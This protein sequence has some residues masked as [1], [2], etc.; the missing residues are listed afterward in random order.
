MGNEERKYVYG[1]KVEE[2][3]RLEAQARALEDVI[4]KELEIL[5]LKSNMKV[6]DAGCGTGAVTRMMAMK[7]HP[8][9]VYG[10]DFD[11]M[12]IDDAVKL[13]DYQG[14]HNV[15]FEL[16][17]IN[18]LKFNE[19]TFDLSYCRLV[20]MHVRDPV[21]TITELKRVTKIC[22]KGWRWIQS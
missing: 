15:K 6:L 10:I 12:F 14:V 19:A 4:L 22:C 11:P 13:A 3:M 1:G 20:L 2:V 16:G 17:D 5:G 9:K 7:V 18:A 21:K 8:E